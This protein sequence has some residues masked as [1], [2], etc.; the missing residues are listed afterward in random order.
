MSGTGVSGLVQ[1]AAHC[2]VEQGMLVLQI[3]RSSENA[4]DCSAEIA[5]EFLLYTLSLGGRRNLLE[6]YSNG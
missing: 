2:E 3:G 4:N 6:C 5:G 1:L